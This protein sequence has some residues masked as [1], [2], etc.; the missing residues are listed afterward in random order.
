[1]SPSLYIDKRY[2]GM[3]VHKPIGS[4][5]PEFLKKAEVMLKALSD[6]WRVGLL[7][8][9]QDGTLD[10]PEVWDAWSN[11]HIERLPGAGDLKDV[12]KAVDKWFHRKEYTDQTE[13]DYRNAIG[14]VTNGPAKL[15]DL[16]RL[17][18][19]YRAKCKGTGKHRMFNLA[20]SAT[21][22]LL[23]STFNKHHR[24][25]QDVAA[26]EPLSIE[27]AEIPH[28]SVAFCRE[29]AERLGRNGAMW[30]AMCIT[31]MNPKE[32]WG[33][34]K[35]DGDLMR[36]YGTKRVGRRRIV[37]LLWVPVKP[38]ITR[39]GF[40]TALQKLDVDVTPKRGRNAYAQ[41][42]EE[43]GVLKSHR[44]AYLG[45]GPKTMN[46]LY[47]RHEMTA[48]IEED[49]AKMKALIGGDLVRLRVER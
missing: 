20:R 35:V 32:Y 21:Q 12:S 33:R 15:G 29:I 6:Q 36:V 25:Y 18:E 22:A 28:L 48:H 5:D 39:E 40:K 17:L 31:G 7:Q 27:K 30:W 8:L 47:T 49:A 37:P 46:D 14:Y 1:M 34:W 4:M 16:P 26:V 44:D 45:H 24:L 38:Q 11:G 19:R 42:L 10:I 9:I 43:A 41:W 3:R 23:K 2:H 13:R